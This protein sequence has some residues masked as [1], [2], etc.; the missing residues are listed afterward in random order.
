[1]G[2]R[3]VQVVAFYLKGDSNEHNSKNS[4]RYVAFFSSG[5]PARLRAA[6]F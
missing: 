6:R 2:I 3:Q 5:L 1:M 4:V